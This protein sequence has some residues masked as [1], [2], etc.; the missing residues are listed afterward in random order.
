MRHAEGQG[1]Q[2][3]RGKKTRTNGRGGTEGPRETRD[4]ERG[5][6]APIKQGG[7]QPHKNGTGGHYRQMRNKGPEGHP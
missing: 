3:D 2:G 1:A 5:K 4:T 6:K 7:A